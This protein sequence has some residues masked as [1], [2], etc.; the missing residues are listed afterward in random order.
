MKQCPRCQASNPDHFRFCNR[1]GLELSQGSF[2]SNS[3][4][5]SQNPSQMY[6]YP[7]G[8][9]PQ[10]QY[11]QDPSFYPGKP[12]KKS[13][14]TGL[15]IGLGAAA[16]LVVI[17]SAV[18]II[19]LRD[20][21][22]KGSQSAQASY[23]N[24]P[25]TQDSQYASE[26]LF[27]SSDNAGASSAPDASGDMSVA[28]LPDLTDS[29]NAQ[30][31]GE[32]AGDGSDGASSSSPEAASDNPAEGT[33]KA[34]PQIQP[35]PRPSLMAGA[36]PLNDPSLTPSVPTYS[37]APDFSNVTNS[38]V[39]Y[40]SDETKAA[41]AANG[42]AVSKGYS[43]EFFD[44]Y[45]DNRY[46]YMANF[47]TVDSMMHTYHLYFA[48]LQKGTEKNYLSSSLAAL[49]LQML[50]KA[51]DQYNALKGTEWEEAAMKNVAFFAI[52]ASL[53][54]EGVS[55]PAEVS[56]IVLGEVS[57][58]ND[59][60]QI[61]T[62]L[63]TGLPE[64]YSQYKPRGYYEGDPQLEAY[65]RAMM[66]YGRLN[67]KQKE[68]VLDRSAL[69]ITL[70]LD[71]ETLPAWESIYTITS[72]FAGTSDDNG[73][74][75]YKPLL[76]AAYGEGASLSSLPGNNEGWETFHALTAQL[77]PPRI[78]S[79]PSPDT[80]GE[81]DNMSENKGF[82]FMGQRF[83]LDE[84]IFQNLTYSAVKEKSE[85]DKRM[86]PDVLDAAAAMGS[87]EALNILEL[88]GA[89]SY[90]GYMENMQMLREEVASATDE[91]WNASLYSSWLYTLQPLLEKKGEGYP[92]FMQ[93]YLWARKD[94][95]T[96]SGSFTEL[97]HDTVLYAKQMM[98]E[99]GGGEIPVVDDRG[100]VEPEP[101]VFSRLAVLT[102]K[103]A[104]GLKGYGMLNETDEENLA[105]LSSLARQLMTISE[106][107]L[108]NETLTDAEYELIRGYG[109]SLE[110]FWLETVKDEAAAHEDAYLSRTDQF[111]AALVVDIATDPN[112]S[113][114]E[115]A[116]GNPSIIWVAC[117][118]DGQLK[119]CSGTV[120]NFY[121]FTWPASDR[122]TDKEWRQM[123]GIQMNDDGSYNYSSDGVQPVDKPEWTKA[124]RT[125]A[126]YGY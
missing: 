116:T 106:K 10:G 66:W 27:G 78:N 85:T 55:F 40:V 26:D 68:E 125:N 6:S 53:Q 72:F 9:Y 107:E 18:L 122:L 31:G 19:L 20:S 76:D 39:V 87:E 92:V 64:D 70:A 8:Q 102:E 90:P 3:S 58:I 86:L 80:G 84:A 111:P 57:L 50:A 29:L 82:R 100:Y 110:H 16:C 112:G 62:S 60:T 93:N 25:L 14:R 113:C 117:V 22:G 2:S 4:G 52:G 1:C 28:G 97:K 104:S 71:E 79:V 126:Q 65:F 105:L 36:A 47:V 101:E 56:D 83:T 109:G 74:Y 34:L 77:D 45:E 67:Y 69:L 11:P 43:K 37:V 115:V 114:L 46:S 73:Y 123:M 21:S 12:P 120:F 38:Q 23:Q 15:I 96:F 49:S 44:L 88:Q 95:E 99:M 81:V 41:I 98:A 35:L 5:S 91:Q 48:H 32:G 63:L 54:N 121:Q 33:G 7:Q 94:L 17:L 30:N 13:S 42:F 103:T 51:T 124:Y 89:T 119:I 24:E 118:V 59:H 61:T 108:R 75:E